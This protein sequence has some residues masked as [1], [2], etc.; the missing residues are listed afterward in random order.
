MK[1]W[2]ILGLLATVFT[3]LGAIL[4]LVLGQQDPVGYWVGGVFLLIGLGMAWGA[5]PVR[6]EEH[7]DEVAPPE[8]RPG[9]VSCRP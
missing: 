1:R 2:W 9:E 5:W 7:L 6:S 3:V 4:A 8:V